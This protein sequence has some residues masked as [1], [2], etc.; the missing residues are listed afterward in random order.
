MVINVEVVVS[1][2]YLLATRSPL[3]QA[4]RSSA[5]KAPICS[6]LKFLNENGPFSGA[7]AGTLFHPIY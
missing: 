5:Q 3:G 1:S 2:R 6:E 4:T 7:S